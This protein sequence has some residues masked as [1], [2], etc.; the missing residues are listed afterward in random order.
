MLRI[1]HDEKFAEW[2]EH[3]TEEERQHNSVWKFS[4]ALILL[5]A[6]I[7]FHERS[8]EQPQVAYVVT[9][10]YAGAVHVVDRSSGKKVEIRDQTLVKRALSGQIKRGDV[11]HF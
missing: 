10:V 3:A 2:Y 6:L 4:L 9:G 11:I 1:E 5:S 7:L 8:Q